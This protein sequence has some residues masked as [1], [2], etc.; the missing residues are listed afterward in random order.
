MILYWRLPKPST[1]VNGIWLC[2]VCMNIKWCP[3]AFTSP[4]HLQ[5]EPDFIMCVY[6]TIQFHLEAY[7]APT[8]LQKEPDF[9]MCV[10]NTIQFRLKAYTA[11]THL[12]KEPDFIMYVYNTIQFRLEAYTAPTHLQMEWWLT[13]TVCNITFSDISVNI[14]IVLRLDHTQFVS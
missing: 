11:P 1:C 9:I 12:Q 8:H 10:Y 7:T 14:V 5:K 13:F 3:E 4:T 6:N 2:N